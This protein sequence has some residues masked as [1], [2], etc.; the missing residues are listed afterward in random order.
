MCCSL[1]IPHEFRSDV[2]KHI[3]NKSIRSTNIHVPP[4]SLNQYTTTYRAKRIL[5]AEPADEGIDT[6]EGYGGYGYASTEQQQH[7]NMDYDDN[8]GYDYE[9]NY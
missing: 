6:Y 8:G 5:D 4:F 1:F 2:R 7:N 3:I 9:G